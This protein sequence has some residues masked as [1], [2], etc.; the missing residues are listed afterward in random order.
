[1]TNHDLGRRESEEDRE[2][3]PNMIHANI[4]LASH[5]GAAWLLDAYDDHGELTDTAWAFRSALAARRFC[6]EWAG[7]KLRWERVEGY[8][9]RYLRTQ[10]EG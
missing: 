8:G 7:D 6:E 2:P 9:G 10:W 5:A 4:T 1:M 3:D